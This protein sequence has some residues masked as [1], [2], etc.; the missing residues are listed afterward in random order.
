MR[1]VKKECS[2]EEKRTLSREEKKETPSGEASLQL[3]K[4]LEGTSSTD[5]AI[6]R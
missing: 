5:G 3:V 6:Q 1:A 4:E 2:V